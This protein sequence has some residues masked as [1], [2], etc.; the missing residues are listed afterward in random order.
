MAIYRKTGERATINY[1]DRPCRLN[2]YGDSFTQAAQVSDGETWAEYLAAHLG[3]PVR[4]FG[5]GGYG[6]YQAYRR[7]LREEATPRATEYAILNIWDIDDH[8][9]SIDK[10]RWLRMAEN[11]RNSPGNL[12]TFH[13][14]PW[15]HIRLDLN[16]GKAIEHENP[17][18]TPKSLYQL[19]DKDH[20]YEHFRDDLVVQ[21][22]VAKRM[23]T[24]V[25]LANLKAVAAA[26]KVPADFS[27]PEATAQTA[28]ALHLE[29]ALRASMRIVEKARAF[30][31]EKNKKLM[32]LLSCGGGSVGRACR[33]LPRLDQPFV[34]FLKRTGVPFI[35][36]LPKHVED[37]KAFNLS[38]ADYVKRYYIGHY[39]PQ[40]NHFFAFAIKDAL[41]DW[42]EPKPIAYRPGS[43]TIRP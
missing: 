22:Q 23:G 28:G 3:E 27:S 30:A 15:A 31:R 7:M 26:L 10:W 36:V 9:R 25:D 14:N 35:D 43:E 38:P 8:M 37:F 19:C 5:I 20:V 40:G 2:V 42:L 1:A 13:G 34:D 16:T 17:Y 6:A 4:N 24:G 12:H 41:V 39:K 32:I 21:L 11:R 33:G 18:P 29:Y